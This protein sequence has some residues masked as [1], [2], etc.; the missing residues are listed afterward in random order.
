MHPFVLAAAL[1]LAA[2]GASRGDVPSG[3]GKWIAQLENAGRSLAIADAAT[4]AVRHV[5]PLESRDHVETRAVALI[6]VPARRSF[7]VALDGIPELWEIALYQDAGPFHQGFVHSYET[8][9]EESLAAEEG[10]FARLRIILDAPV[11]A[12][13][14]D[15]GK[16][17]SVIGTRA[18]GTRVRISLA[19]KREV[20]V[21]PPG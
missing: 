5:R 21:L 14:P 16:R 7:V 10:L 17:Y 2:A 1:F 6:A 9:M 4:G 19:A 8:G 13:A 11:V 20:A 18:D 12:L 15:P 3:D